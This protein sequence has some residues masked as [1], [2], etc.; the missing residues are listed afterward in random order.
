MIKQIQLSCGQFAFAT[1]AIKIH[2]LLLQII[3]PSAKQKKIIKTCFHFS[4]ILLL[5]SIYLHRTMSWCK[6]LSR[7]ENEVQF[8]TEHVHVHSHQS[9]NTMQPILFVFLHSCTSKPCCFTTVT[10]QETIT[11][12][13]IVLSSKNCSATGLKIELY[14]ILCL[15]G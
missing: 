13:T 11:F 15:R 9:H 5:P 12:R 10:N 2:G 7:P 4:N 14:H 3:F 8:L 6:T 1:D